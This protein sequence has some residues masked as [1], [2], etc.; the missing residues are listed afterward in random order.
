MDL[1]QN[2]WALA[3]QLGV[4]LATSMEQPCETGYYEWNKRV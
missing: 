3:G 4:L 1:W 2:P